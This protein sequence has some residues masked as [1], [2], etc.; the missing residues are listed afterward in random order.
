MAMAA[1]SA[2]PWSRSRSSG[3]NSRGVADEIGQRA[4]DLAARGPEWSRSHPAQAHPIGDLVVVAA[5]RDARVGDVVLRPDR[6]AELGGEAVDATAHREAQA[7]KPRLHL[8]IR[9]AGDHDRD[10]EGA[11]LAH[12]R[13]VR[14]VGPQ[15]AHRLVD[16]PFED[17]LGLAEGG[18]PGGDVA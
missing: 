11:V 12:P 3:S 1:W 16:D 17:D 10:E 14:A 7:E 13:Q 2:R 18:D 9:R 8:G 5:V 15:Q 6:L 4:D